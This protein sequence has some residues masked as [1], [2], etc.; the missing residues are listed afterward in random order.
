MRDAVD[1]AGREAELAARAMRREHGVHRLR[2]A[3]DRVDGARA[4]AQVAAD[5]VRLVDARDALQA[6]VAAARVE[7]QRV[8]A[9]QLGEPL[10][11]F[12]RRPAGSG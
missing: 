12:A 9:E 6:R 3:D 11:R 2:N 8:A 1:G 4:R 10:D 5:A 7:R